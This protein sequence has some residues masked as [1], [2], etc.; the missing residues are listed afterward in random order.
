[1]DAPTDRPRSPYREAPPPPEEPTA[2]PEDDAL[3]E[4]ALLWFLALIGALRLGYVTLAHGPWDGETCA[5]GLAA[6]FSARR[7]FTME[8][9]ARRLP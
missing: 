9:D 4:R 3:D 7:L 2:L 6:F 5:L 1:M 8:R